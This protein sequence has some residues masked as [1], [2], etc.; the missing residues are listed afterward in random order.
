MA[1]SDSSPLAEGQW[2]WRRLYVFLASGALWHLLADAIGRIEPEG[3]PRVAA[4]LM[5]LLALTLI[6]YLV[7][8]SA[9]QL[10]VLMANLRIRLTQGGSR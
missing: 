7:A 5:N 4:G 8:P 9:Q 10:V 6:L 1:D 3:L 2:L